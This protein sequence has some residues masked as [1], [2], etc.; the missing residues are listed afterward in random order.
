[1]TIL[2]PGD[3]APRFILPDQDN[4]LVKLLDY[5]GKRVLIYFYP[6]A[7]TPNCTIQAGNLRDNIESF[8]TANIEILGISIDTPD[9]LLKFS[10]KEMLNFT[11]L[12][13]KEHKV[14]EQFGIWGKKKFMGKVYYGVHRTT[15]LIDSVGKIEKIF[16]SF[17]ANTHHLIVLKY[18]EM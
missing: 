17:Q 15:F 6:K 4:Q 7:M 5:I 14:S 10:E 3:Y 16:S 18:I 1:M 2:R 12:S 13:D 8:N 11:L 9:K